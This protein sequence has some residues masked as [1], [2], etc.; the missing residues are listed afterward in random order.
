MMPEVYQ[1]LEWDKFFEN[2]KSRLIEVKS[3][4][5]VPNKQHG[6]GLTF[7]LSQP[8]GGAI[9]GIWSLIVG[10]CSQQRRPREG[11]LTDDGKGT[12][13][14]WTVKAMAYRWRRPEQEVRDALQMLVSDDV[15]WMRV[16]KCPSSTPEVL[17]D[18]QTNEGRNG[19]TEGLRATHACPLN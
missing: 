5:A 14:P 4:A 18:G 19:R 11:W 13:R 7:M 1:I 3:W 8:N 9:Y 10:A 2:S 15:A 6:M 17:S 12:G 16:V